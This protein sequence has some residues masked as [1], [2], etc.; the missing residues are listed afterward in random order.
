M[1]RALVER[2]RR[3][4]RPVLRR[5]G[6]TRWRAQRGA[7]PSRT[8]PPL[9]RPLGRRRHRG[10][11]AGRCPPTA[12]CGVVRRAPGAPVRATAPAAAPRRWNDERSRRPSTRAAGSSRRRRLARGLI[13]VVIRVVRVRPTASLAR[14]SVAL[15]SATAASASVTPR[16]EAGQIERREVALGDV[17]LLRALADPGGDHVGVGEA[18]ARRSRRRC[19]RAPPKAARV[20]SSRQRVLL[21]RRGDV[22]RQSGRH[23][24]VAIARDA[25][26]RAT[27]PG[28]SLRRR[29]TRPTS[30]SRRWPRSRA[31]RRWHTPVV[32]RKRRRLSRDHVG[33]A[34]PGAALASS[35]S[36]SPG[37]V[38]A[39][40]GRRR[41]HRSLA[42]LATFTLAVGVMQTKRATPAGVSALLADQQPVH[43]CEPGAVDGGGLRAESLLAARRRASVAR[44]R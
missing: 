6:L 24:D 37:G 15:E 8:V 4:A 1:A 30:R 41:C 29:S 21:H 35:A 39:S 34:R 26:A 7:P 38:D 32:R 33:A 16:R 42:T 13:D 11:S 2:A 23:A 40:R 9:P 28:R 20:L 14:A 22:G 31:G 44:R 27:A 17:E 10:R 43:A 3:A 19:A 12:L 18:A 5:S 25:H 36:E